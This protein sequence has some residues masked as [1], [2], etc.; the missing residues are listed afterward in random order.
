[1]KTLIW[2]LKLINLSPHHFYECFSNLWR[3][4]W[5]LYMKNQTIKAQKSL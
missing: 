4:K 2:A 3:D 5:K 1:M